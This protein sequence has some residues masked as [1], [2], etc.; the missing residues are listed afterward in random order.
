MIQSLARR[1]GWETEELAPGELIAT[2]RR[3]HAIAVVQIRFDARSFDIRYRNSENLLRSEGRIHRRY[4]RWV[5]ALAVGIQRE[6]EYL[7]GRR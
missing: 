6:A 2:R 1:F 5:E 3:G 4:N 7:W